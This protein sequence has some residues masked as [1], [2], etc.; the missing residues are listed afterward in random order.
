MATEDEAEAMSPEEAADWAWAR[1]YARRAP[2]WSDEKW[3]RMNAL[4]GMV[5]R[6]ADGGSA[7]RRDPRTP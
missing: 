2:E 5:V 6:G 3:R 4:L 7:A 1:D